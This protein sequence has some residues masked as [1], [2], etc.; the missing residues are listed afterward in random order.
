[1]RKGAVGAVLVAAM[2]TAGCGGATTPSAVVF[3]R[4]DLP[5][6]VEAVTLTDFGNSLLVG[7]RKDEH[8]GLYRRD[9]GGALTEVPVKGTTPYGL[10]A[11][12]TAIAT[13]G[14]AIVAVGGERGGAHGNVRWSVWDG[15]ATGLTERRQGFSTFGGYGA[16]DLV[17]TAITPSGPVVVGTW[18]SKDAG[19]DVATWTPEPGGEGYWARGESETE[20]RSSATALTFP[21]AATR[22]GEG[23]LAVG[24]QAAQ[25]DEQAVVWRSRT[26][27]RD[28]TRTVLSSGTAM[29]VHCVGESCAVSGRSGG[30][31]TIWR[32]A[33][34]GWHPLPGVPDVPVGDHDV[35]A[36]PIE[37]DGA[38]VQVVWDGAKVRVARF[39]DGQWGVR[40]VDGPSGPV[41]AASLVGTEVQVIAGGALWRVDAGALR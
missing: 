1:M 18:E 4:I 29:A 8:P 21:L 3:G 16:G 7:T 14:K 25:G 5:P 12:W 28:W 33:A 10:L 23:L 13:D 6:G 11:R 39:A 19:F 20:L 32:L 17:G 38:L 30:K 22:L 27:T 24:W 36:P 37:V 40:D 15:D 2:V 26:G 34:D 9:G 31:L 41:S 35:V